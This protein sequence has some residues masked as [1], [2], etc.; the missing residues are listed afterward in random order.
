M[1]LWVLD[2]THLDH[3]PGT[4][5][6]AEVLAA[7]D[8]MNRPV[9]RTSPSPIPLTLVSHTSHLRHGEGKDKDII[10]VPQPSNSPRDP[11]NW[12][13]WKKDFMFLIFSS[14]TAVIGA[15]LLML[16][17]GY[18]VIA[19]EFGIVSFPALSPRQT[20]MVVV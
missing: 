17:P 11:L 19:E 15:W 13:L 6:L 5:P 7:R 10:L 8:Q 18:F 20:L 12:P 3:V 2:D 4:A 14:N 9:S 1:G 16:S